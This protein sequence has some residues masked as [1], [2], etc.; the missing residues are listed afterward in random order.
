MYF[1]LLGKYTDK[2]GQG[3]DRNALTLY[4]R[5]VWVTLTSDFDARLLTH[6]QGDVVVMQGA[7]VQTYYE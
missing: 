1:R 3:G 4:L 2:K 6:S 7:G 5:H